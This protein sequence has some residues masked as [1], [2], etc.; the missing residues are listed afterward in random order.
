[1]RPNPFSVSLD[2]VQAAEVLVNASAKPMRAHVDGGGAASALRVMNAV[3]LLTRLLPIVFENPAA[4]AG[5]VDQLFWQNRI[6]ALPDSPTGVSSSEAGV[7]AVNATAAAPAAAPPAAASGAAEPSEPS[8]PVRW[9]PLHPGATAADRPPL[10]RQLVH[11]VMRCLF[12]P[13]LTV[14]LAQWD[15]YATRKETAEAA[16]E[17]AAAAAAAA[18]DTAAASGSAAP[19]AAVRVQD[20]NAVWP[21]LMWTGGVTFPPVPRS[22]DPG[23]MANRIEL[24]RLLVATCSQPLFCM[25]DAHNP[26]RSRFMDEL[27]GGACP[28]APTLFYSLL[29]E[30]LA[31]DPVGW[32]IPYASAM[33]TDRD[34][35]MCTAALQALILLLDYSPKVAAAAAASSGGSEGTAADAAG[36]AQFNVFRMLLSSISDPSDVGRLLSAFARLL[37]SIPAAQESLLPQ[38]RKPIAFH[39]ELLVLLWKLLDENEAFHR[40]VLVGSN[41]A[42][43]SSVLVAPL[44]YLMWQGRNDVTQVGLV[45]L[46]TFILLLLS[47]ERSFCVSLNRAAGM[48][49]LPDMVPGSYTATS[50]LSDL[51]ILT[52]HRL[53]VDGHPGLSTLYSC[54][55]TIIAN[56]SPYAKSVSPAASAKL[57]SLLELFSAPRFLFAQPNN[58]AYCQMLVEAFSNIIQY[59]YESNGVTAYL[60]VTRREIFERLASLNADEWAASSLGAATTAAAPDQPRQEPGA[61]TAAERD[62]DAAARRNLVDRLAQDR[63]VAGGAKPAPVLSTDGTLVSPSGASTAGEPSGEQE[64]PP[65]TAQ[66]PTSANGAGKDEAQI[67]RP[68]EAWFSTVRPQIPL[69]APLRLIAY[70]APLIS[71]HI[72]IN[73]A[74]QNDEDIIEFLRFTTVVGVLPVPHPILMRKYQPNEFTSLWFSTYAWSTV[75]LHL[76]EELPMFD[77]TAIRLFQITVV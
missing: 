54:F 71:E 31:Y 30:A 55:L 32:G 61:P 23:H 77:A 60:M 5:F 15:M 26:P 53:I 3:R 51:A 59:Q 64:A 28:F 48:Q 25:P 37:A 52:F 8:E 50:S 42:G 34:E 76:C 69:S 14:T 27:T 29:N 72:R 57:L 16:A 56:L 21:M 44:L 4:S 20:S 12:F 68:S 39:R 19:V 45:H 17:A 11:A 10:G 36:L 33:V 1:V 6:P 7:A 62:E 67:W 73:G 47:G 49:P 66:A 35:P 24:L 13:G 22:A 38:S 18:G 40:F 65:A 75:Y 2:C 46:C 9:E 43:D 63:Y 41:A 74:L 70:L 58:Y